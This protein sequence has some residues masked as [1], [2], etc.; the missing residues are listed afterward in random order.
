MTRAGQWRLESEGS[1]LLPEAGSGT[2]LTSAGGS[3]SGV[4]SRTALEVSVMVTDGVTR[5]GTRVINDAWVNLRAMTEI[6]SAVLATH[7]D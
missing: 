7:S 4:A 5:T 1:L 3:G 6:E 2:S